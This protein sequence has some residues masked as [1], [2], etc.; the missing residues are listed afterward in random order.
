MTNMQ[1]VFQTVDSLTPEEREQ[2]RL[3]LEQHPAPPVR[4]QT[5]IPG[6]FVGGWI[7]EDFTAELPDEFWGFDKSFDE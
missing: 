3:Y 4:P 5:R 2:L 1:A 6:L 7:S